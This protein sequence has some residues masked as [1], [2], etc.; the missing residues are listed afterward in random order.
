MP[1]K[2]E[3]RLLKA[4]FL[5]SYRTSVIQISFGGRAFLPPLAKIGLINLNNLRT[6]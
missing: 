2:Y 3:I 1:I 6:F 5:K 4:Q